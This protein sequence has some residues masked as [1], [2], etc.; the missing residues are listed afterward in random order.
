MLNAL[1]LPIDPDALL[2]DHTRDLDDAWRQVAGRL[3]ANAEVSIDAEGRLHVGSVD[4]V[5]DPPTLKELRRRCEAMLPR[6]DV[7]ELI[8]EVMSWQPRFIEAFTAASGGESRLADLHVTIAAALTAHALN[9]GYTPVISPGVHALTR[10][11]D[12]PRRPEL[13]PG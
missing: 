10:A 4:A 9:I 8:L 11:R 5:A 3:D 12:K 7:G 6:V 1:Q 13:P 2:A